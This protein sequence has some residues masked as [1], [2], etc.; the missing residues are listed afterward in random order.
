[1]VSVLNV[2]IIV[3]SVKLIILRP[4][5]SATKDTMLT[6]LFVVLVLRTAQNVIMVLL[7]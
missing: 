2:L 5:L 1:M 7:V 4:V 3:P 6:M